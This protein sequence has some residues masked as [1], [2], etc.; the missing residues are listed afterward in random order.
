MAERLVRERMAGAFEDERALFRRQAVFAGVYENNAWGRAPDGRPYYSDSP[1]HL[2]APLRRLISEFIAAKSI[3]TVV[4]LRTSEQV[5][6][7]AS[8]G[9]ML[10]VTGEP[11]LQIVTSGASQVNRLPG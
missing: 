11:D 10:N 1:A 3:R 4:D 2:T 7:S 5:F 9:S 8:G 6:G